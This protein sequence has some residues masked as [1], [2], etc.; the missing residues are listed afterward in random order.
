MQAHRR[1]HI[2]Y[3]YTWYRHSLAIICILLP[4][5]VRANI[6]RPLVSNNYQLATEL[7]M[8]IPKLIFFHANS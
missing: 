6:G 7:V 3:S 4:Y 5:I 2:E 8:V 1:A